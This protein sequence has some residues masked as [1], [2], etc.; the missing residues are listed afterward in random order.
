MGTKTTQFPPYVLDWLHAR[1][2][3][4]DVLDEA[5]ISWRERNGSGQIVI[6]VFDSRGREVYSKYR[7]DPNSTEGPKYKYDQFAKALLYNLHRVKDDGSPIYVVEGEFDALL[8]NSIG[9]NAVSSTG[10]SQTFPAAWA[11]YFAN[12]SVYICYDAD[13]AGVCG[14][15]KVQEVLPQA[16]IVFLNPNEFSGKDVTDYIQERGY[17]DF[18][19]AVMNARKYVIPKRFAEI[20]LEKKELSDA[21][22][23]IRNLQQEI[24]FE[25]RDLMGKRNAWFGP[26][27][28][29]SEILAK[30]LEEVERMKVSFDR[31]AVEGDSR[32][33][34]AKAV[35]ITSL[36]KFNHQWYAPC[37]WHSEKTPSMKYNKPDSAWPNTVK[38]FG[39]GQM[40]DAIDVV[41]K[42]HNLS[43]KEAI[44]FLLHT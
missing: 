19:S 22:H 30:R 16:G 42:M 13:G 27:D 40:G 6:P 17:A 25:R 11:G 32:V 15:F 12:R 33:D 43:F 35:P 9:L 14:A 44:S 37:L 21:S 34:K 2:I 7:R 38:C 26:I 5:R 3:S 39:C 8:L 41:M 24:I 28:D 10:G 18:Q 29:Y 23:K 36:V 1:G 4:D 31:G 20:P